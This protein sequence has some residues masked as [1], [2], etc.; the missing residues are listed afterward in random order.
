[1]LQEIIFQDTSEPEARALAGELRDR[2]H[3]MLRN[4][5][6]KEGF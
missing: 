2:C 4:Q 5:H 3:R 1:M 6:P